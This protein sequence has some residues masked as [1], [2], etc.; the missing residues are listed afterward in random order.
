MEPTTS[1]KLHSSRCAVTPRPSWEIIRRTKIDV[2]RGSRTCGAIASQR[3]IREWSSEKSSV[4]SGTN[5]EWMK[6]RASM[7]S[8]D[9]SSSS[10]FL[11][12]LS[13]SVDY[14]T[15][16]D[17]VIVF[18]ASSLIYSRSHSLSLSARWRALIRRLL[19]RCIVNRRGKKNEWEAFFS[20]LRGVIKFVRSFII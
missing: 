4:L 20:L 2:A 3:S 9:S 12:P 5:S 10:S 17:R 11:L 7:Y 18:L 8:R 15:E 14:P 16:V 1:G 13:R 6:S 19:M